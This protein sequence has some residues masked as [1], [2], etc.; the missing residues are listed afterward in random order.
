[1]TP[2][3]LPQIQQIMDTLICDVTYSPLI[4]D[5]SVAYTSAR[6]NNLAGD[7]YK[8]FVNDSDKE[9]A[10]FLYL[11]E[12]GHIVFTHCK[13]M[14]Q[15]MD[16][17]LLTKIASSYSKVRSI[18]PNET[19]YLKSVTSFLFNVVMDFEVN[20]R[21]FNQEEWDYMQS[22]LQILLNS[23]DTKGFWPQD[24]NFPPEKTWNEYLNLILQDPLEFFTKYKFLK[25]L[26]AQKSLKPGQKSQWT[27]KEFEDFKKEYQEKKLSTKDINDLKQTAKNH[28]NGDFGIPVGGEGS[29][30]ETAKPVRID[31]ESY[32]SKIELAKKVM[33]VLKIRTTRITKRDIM[34]NENRRKLNTGVIVPKTIREDT[35]KNARLFLLM[36]VSGSVDASLV[37]DFISTFKDLSNNYK[38][39]RVINWSTKLVCDWKITDKNPHKY[40]GGTNIAP[41]I[42]YIRQQYSLKPKDIL[43]VISDF[44]DNLREWQSELSLTNCKKYAIN[45]NN[46]YSTTE[47]PGFK[48]IIKSC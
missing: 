16:K 3:K 29:T 12:C 40:G 7:I 5:P 33:K 43:F 20:S 6:S 38:D 30:K 36:D 25:H 46:Y 14:N 19:N 34:Y 41:G 2:S 42:R 23:P 13:N 27:Q 22:K 44:Q 18:F 37:N 9:L 4:F 8:I 31:F 24:Y 10:Q 39:T 48:S 35:N 32:K 21:M 15:R 45:W 1:M 26:A 28:T 47:N 11:H 17:F